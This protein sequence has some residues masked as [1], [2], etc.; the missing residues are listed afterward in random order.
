MSTSEYRIAGVKTKMDVKQKKLQKSIVQLQNRLE[1]LKQPN[2]V[3]DKYDISFLS[4]LHR[5]PKRKMI[6]PS[7]EAKIGQQYLWH[8]PT[9]H[10]NSGDKL[11]IIGRNGA[12]KTT[13]LNDIVSVIPP[14]YKICYF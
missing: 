10:L 14:T 11:G 12:G 13:Y 1:E 7:H 3:E 5:L 6:I 4:Q 8:T 9:I 2:R